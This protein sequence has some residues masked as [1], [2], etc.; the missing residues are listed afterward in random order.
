MKTLTLDYSKKALLD[1]DVAEK[2]FNSGLNT[3]TSNRE[4]D[5]LLA[6]LRAAE[7]D[8]RRAFY[9]DTRDRNTLDNCMVVG[10]KWIREMCA[11]A[12]QN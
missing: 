4:W 11:K 5:A 12:G 2:A 9:E 7:D 8:V 6:T 3:V 10:I 1:L